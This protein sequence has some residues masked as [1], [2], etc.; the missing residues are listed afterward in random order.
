[1]CQLHALMS[2][3]KP[4][5][6]LRILCRQ[7]LPSK[8]GAW[9]RMVGSDMDEWQ[10]RERLLQGPWAA[11]GC[12]PQAKAVQGTELVALNPWPQQIWPLLHKSESAASKIRKGKFLSLLLPATCRTYTGTFDFQLFR[13]MR[14]APYILGLWRLPKI[15]FACENWCLCLVKHRESIIMLC[16]DIWSD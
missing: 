16:I 7:H 4:S 6:Q 3:A 5:S 8:H 2:P 1:M 12:H 9:N 10:L 15:A 14:A 13:G 11:Q